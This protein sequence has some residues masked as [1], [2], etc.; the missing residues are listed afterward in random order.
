M[1]KKSLINRDTQNNKGT[2]VMSNNNLNSKALPLFMQNWSEAERT[3]QRLRYSC[4]RLHAHFPLDASDV[5]S[6]NEEL[7]ERL[8]AF[9]VRFADLQDCIG[10][11]LF[12]GVLALE[13]ETA[14]TM[15][16]LLN[17]MEK[18]RIITSVN[19]WRRL[20]E[21]RNAF[22][23][24]YPETPEQRAAALN[25]AWIDHQRLHQTKQAI[26]DYLQRYGLTDLSKTA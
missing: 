1:T 13:D 23:H 3:E 22:S 12:R 4:S 25:L 17:S 18:R 21:I 24:D 8:D 10:N 26:A 16:D 7:L 6:G 15:I 14:L 5:S 9:R 19:D 20:R 2:A 11:K